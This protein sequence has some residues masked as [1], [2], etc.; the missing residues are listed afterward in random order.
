MVREAQQLK[1]NLL[2]VIAALALGVAIVLVP[3]VTRAEI[4]DAQLWSRQ[5]LSQ[6]LRD[7]DGQSSNVNLPEVSASDLEILTLGFIAALIM[8]LWLRSRRPDRKHRWIGYVP[9]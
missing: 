5:S 1:R 8:Y 6:A 4:M 7:L 3:L 2:Y 9:Y